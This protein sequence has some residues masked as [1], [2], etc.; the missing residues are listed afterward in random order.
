VQEYKVI[1]SVAVQ[2][3]L[4]CC[5]CTRLCVLCYIS[6]ENGYKIA[7]NRRSV[8]SIWLNYNAGMNF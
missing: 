1:Q 4:L 3:M 7:L 5:F 2:D 6:V 8:S